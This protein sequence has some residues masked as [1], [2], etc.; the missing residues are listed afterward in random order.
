VAA[1]G[2]EGGGRDEHD[3]GVSAESERG[4]GGRERKEGG[5][6]MKQTGT[7]LTCL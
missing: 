4:K 5:N 2:L 7:C 6:E 3:S 1:Y